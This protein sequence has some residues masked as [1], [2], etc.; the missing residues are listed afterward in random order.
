MIKYKWCFRRKKKEEVNKMDQEKSLKLSKRAD[1]TL[2]GKAITSFGR[3]FYSSTFSIYTFLI[4]RRRSAVVKAFNNY[5]NIANIKEESKRDAVSEKYKKAYAN[6][7]SII[8]K[9]ITENIYTKMQKGAATL[10]EEHIMSKYYAVNKFK[11][12]DEVEHRVRLEILALNVDWEN[13]QSSKSDNYVEKYKAFY[14]YNIEELYKAQIRHNAILLANSKE[15]DRD[16][17]EAIYSIIDTYIK[18]ALPILPEKEERNGIIKDYKKY[19]SAIDSYDRKDFLELRKRLTLLGFAKNLFEYSFPVVAQEQCYLEIIEIARRLVA[20]YFTDSEKYAAYEVLLDAIEEYIENVLAYKVYWPSEVE[21]QEYKSLE[22]EWLVMK[23]LARIDYDCYLRKREVLFINYDQKC[24]KRAGINIPEIKEYY[25]E[26]LIIRHAL[27]VLKNKPTIMPG[28]FRTRRMQKADDIASEAISA[29]KNMQ[30]ESFEATKITNGANK[31]L[32]IMLRE[33]YSDVGKTIYI[34]SCLE[35]MIAE[36]VSAL[37]NK[38][39]AVDYLNEMLCESIVDCVSPKA[40]NKAI[41]YLSEMLCESIADC[42]L[43][44]A[45]NKAVDYLSE[46]LCESIADCVAS[47]SASYQPAKV[48]LAEM[49]NES[50]ADSKEFIKY[51]MASALSE[52]IVESLSDGLDANF[53][54]IRLLDMIKES[55]EDTLITKEIKIEIANMLKECYNDTSIVKNVQLALSDM[56]KECDEDTLVTK[57]VKMALS[58]VLS[59][60]YKDTSITKEAKLILKDMITESKVETKVD[61]VENIIN[62]VQ[63]TINSQYTEY[64]KEVEKQ[65][66]KEK[67]EKEEESSFNV[68][69]FVMKSTRNLKKKRKARI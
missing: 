62:D 1:E 30:T 65:I 26:R 48:A 29:L 3:V 4:A 40:E 37:S 13:V 31:A 45:E 18:E 56:K 64:V 10:D 63:S 67:A 42:I 5:L 33:A 28:T 52:M 8:D 32:F 11:G 60:C 16:Q 23:K 7:I 15:G 39:N 61:F 9:Y 43:P 22:E 38:S 34:K 20:N 47:I 59:E 25:K 53:A 24:M 19:V 6:Y 46:M 49:I 14:I 44:K 68:V 50:V 36:S 17:Y 21:K 54:T 27:R 41:D 58:E 51:N 57:N 12:E 2:F 35:D 69:D 66:E 55:Q